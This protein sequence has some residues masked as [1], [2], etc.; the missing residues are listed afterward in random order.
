RLRGTNIR[1]VAAPVDSPNRP[2]GASA[3]VVGPPRESVAGSRVIVT[4]PFASD[5][6][7][8]RLHQ[9]ALE[10]MTL[11][12]MPGAAAKTGARLVPEHIHDHSL[13]DGP[14]HGA[15]SGQLGNKPE[16]PG[17]RHDNDAFVAILPP[18]DGT[19]D[20]WSVSHPS[21]HWTPWG[22]DWSLD[23]YS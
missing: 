16:G 11:L 17:V 12:P 9:A 21:S 22:G 6:A 20:R 8:P 23:Y 18:F 7:T 5:L 14:V 4:Q 2:G 10:G 13:D 3:G 1:S 15:P 19:W